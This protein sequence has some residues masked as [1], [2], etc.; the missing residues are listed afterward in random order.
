M[1]ANDEKLELFKE[2]LLFHLGAQEPSFHEI[3]W[4]EWAAERIK[5]LEAEA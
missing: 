1:N 3:L 5:E 2:A 4:C